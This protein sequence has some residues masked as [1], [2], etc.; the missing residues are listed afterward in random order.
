[1][2][3]PPQ[4]IRPKGMHMKD[5]IATILL[6][7][8]LP[9]F[10]VAALLLSDGVTMVDALG[11]TAGAVVRLLFGGSLLVLAFCLFISSL[12]M[13]ASRTNSRAERW[14]HW[15]GKWRPTLR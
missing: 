11:Y 14:L 1:M 4:P 3:R 12:G 13:F 6:V 5:Q 2:V 10:I 8:S 15:L 9:V 7:L